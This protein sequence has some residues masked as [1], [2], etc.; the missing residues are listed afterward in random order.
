MDAARSKL[1]RSSDQGSGMSISGTTPA[2]WM[3]RV[4]RDLRLFDFRKLLSNLERRTARNRDQA[5]ENKKSLRISSQA[6]LG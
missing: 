5:N 1:L 6:F 2:K 4:L 3:L